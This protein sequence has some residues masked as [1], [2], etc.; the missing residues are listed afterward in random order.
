[1]PP[2]DSRKSAL[3]DSAPR[4]RL[5]L[6]AL[7]YERTAYA[8]LFTLS[9]ACPG[10][11]P[12]GVGLRRLC[13]CYCASCAHTDTVTLTVLTAAVVAVSSPSV[14][15]QRGRPLT[16]SDEPLPSASAVPLPAVAERDGVSAS[17]LCA[18][19]QRRWC[20]GCGCALHLPHL[21]LC[22]CGQLHSPTA[23]HLR[24][25]L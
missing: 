14:A 9:P 23:G 17:E 19:Q 22:G 18:G 16:A 21:R 4:S 24:I 12:G 6:R 1:M 25:P 3:P 11:R 15:V 5:D 13:Y 2:T 7:H 8:S 10:H 20:G